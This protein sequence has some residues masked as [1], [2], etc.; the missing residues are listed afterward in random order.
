LGQLHPARAKTGRISHR[1]H[2]QPYPQSIPSQ[3]LLLGNIDS[4][5]SSHF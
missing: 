2:N 5:T 4:S 1:P 3:V